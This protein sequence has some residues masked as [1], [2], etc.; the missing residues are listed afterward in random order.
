MKL[1]IGQCDMSVENKCLKERT[2]AYRRESNIG[3]LRAYSI[4]MWEKFQIS[5]K[6]I[7]KSI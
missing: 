5:L 4:D 1:P 3:K 2:D 6:I 7:L